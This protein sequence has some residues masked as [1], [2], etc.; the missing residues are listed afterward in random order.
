MPNVELIYD[1]DCPHAEAARG[2][3]RE[4]LAGL[5]MPLHWAEWERSDPH[6][7]PHGREYGSPTILVEGKD[8]AD[9]P[10]F[11][12]NCCRLYRQ[13]GGGVEGAP[14][15]ESVTAALRDR[16][17]VAAGGPST[18]RFRGW[19]AVLPAIGLALLPKVVCPACWP[20]YAGTL[21]VIGLGF[22][23]ETAYLLP[24][25]SLFLTVAV[26]AL[27]FRA[28]RRRGYGP[29][30]A[31]IV[32]AVLVIVGKFVVESDLAM[33]GGVGLLVGASLW[34]TWPNRNGSR[35]GNREACCSAGQ[36]Y[37]IE[38]PGRRISDG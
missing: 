24:L 16:G 32:A 14:S 5:G 26:G 7:P 36:L 31:G 25:T 10:P 12:G 35:S 18:S 8:V 4:A 9:A 6:S 37:Q 17:M 1:A 3:L 38:N 29:F 21:S 2:R 20:A 27:G 30:A 22:L 23:A 34:N 33:F 19:P 28:R 13:Q 11:G 15:I